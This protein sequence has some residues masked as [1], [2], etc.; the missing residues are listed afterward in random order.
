MAWQAVRRDR[1]YY[2]CTGRGDAVLMLPGWAGSITE[3]DW[4]RRELSMGFLVIA[5]DLP[6]SGRSEP[7]PRQYAPTFYLDDAQSFLPFVAIP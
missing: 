3:L 6:G 5:A 7:Q 4:L 2:E 1:I